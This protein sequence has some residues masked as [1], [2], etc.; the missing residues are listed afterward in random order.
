MARRRV[1][2]VEHA[3]V[4]V[5]G[6]G[7]A[8]MSA[9]LACDDR[10]VRLLVTGEPGGD[11]ASALAQGGIAAALAADDSPRLH[12]ADT[13]AAGGGLADP[14][15][16]EILT[17]AAGEAIRR[18]QGLG[19]RF[20]VDARG[21][22][23]LGREGAHGRSRIVHARGDA[24]GAEISRA[25]GSAVRSR[26]RVAV[27]SGVTAHEL[28]RR[29]G[30]VCGVLARDRHGAWVAFV[31]PAV[32]LC[33]GG[34]GRLYAETTNPP[35]ASG[36]GLA[37]A[38]RAGAALIDLEFVQF[39]P[40]ALAV[41]GDPRPL[42]TEAL[43]GAGALLVDGAGRRFLPE[44]DE[45]AELA[46]R[47]VV[48]RAIHQ[49]LE[50]GGRA[51][52]D[53][54]AAIG[55]A[56]PERFPSVFAICRR[57]ALDPRRDLL[58][59]SPAAHY[60]MGGVATGL[61][62]RTSLPGLW[63]AGEVACTG[64]HGSNRLASNSL[65][66]CLVFGARAGEDAARSARLG[67]APLVS[68]T[69]LEVPA[70]DRRRPGLERRIRRLMTARVGVVRRAAPL[71]A[72]L[73]ELESLR[74]AAAAADRVGRN[75]WTVARLVSRAA[76]ERTESAGS[77]FRLDAAAPAT[78]A[79]YRLALTLDPRSGAVGLERVPVGDV[80]RQVRR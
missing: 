44:V 30:A 10:H 7:A 47:D 61:T 8:G 29:G 58:P 43:R 14:R 17:A 3:E 54:R 73:D 13:L 74:G 16:V 31:A 24:T 32:V 5:V 46:P 25:L 50:R 62:G 55:D 1:E 57:H 66:E 11:G 60:H 35:S 49:L 40:T 59:V 23:A 18:L 15:A 65:L 4:L 12:A 39:H 80:R 63:A 9:A 34:I 71:R 38:A 72:A 78:A 67:R 77:H 45:R 22:L 69:D 64:V 33:T 52:L 53:G 28:I 48:A 6:G 68:S 2:R 19:A 70:A 79:G 42:L 37:M 56:W 75:L 27:E 51:Y 36:D 21:R 20:D 26:P 41:A 76:L